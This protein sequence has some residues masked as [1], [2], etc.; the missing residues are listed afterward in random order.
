[1]TLPCQITC[2]YYRSDPSNS[3]DKSC[4]TAS[5]C[6]LHRDVHELPLICSWMRITWS[7]DQPHR[8]KP[9][10]QRTSF[11]VI[12]DYWS[13]LNQRNSRSKVEQINE[14]RARRIRTVMQFEEREKSRAKFRGRNLHRNISGR[15]RGEIS[16]NIAT[17]ILQFLARVGKKLL[18]IQLH[19][20][21]TTDW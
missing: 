10:I 11:R 8:L 1:M 15:R 16:R 14:G 13:V 12:S 21:L 9:S 4:L 3:L 17:S 7:T 6:A 20:N 5:I 19:Y 18:N 2:G